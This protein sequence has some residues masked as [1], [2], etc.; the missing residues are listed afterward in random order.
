VNRIRTIYISAIALS[1]MLALPVALAAQGADAVNRRT[2]VAASSTP[3][4][5]ALNGKDSVSRSSVNKSDEAGNVL[6]GR[7]EIVGLSRLTVN[8]ETSA[9]PRDKG[10]E[11][12]EPPPPPPP[13][14]P[15]YCIR[16]GGQ[17]VPWAHCCGGLTCVALS[18]RAFCL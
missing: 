2:Q 5:A 12:G 3:G 16:Y 8:Q 18:S 6:N 7:S 10:G 9:L 15:A 17:C 13:P 11:K 4:N 14:P 1:A